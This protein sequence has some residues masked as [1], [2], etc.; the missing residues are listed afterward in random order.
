M[1]ELSNLQDKL[2]QLLDRYY[3]LKAHSGELEKTVAQQTETI[4]TLS[5]SKEA[6]MEELQNSQLSS[7]LKSLPEAKSKH[8]KAQLDS[9]LKLIEDNIKHLK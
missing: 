2:A 6:L 5:K 1:Q 8:I 9:I 7:Y 4:K 3:A